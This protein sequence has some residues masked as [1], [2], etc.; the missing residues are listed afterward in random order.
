MK[1]PLLFLLAFLATAFAAKAQ[2]Q[3][4]FQLFAPAGDVMQRPT[5]I[6]HAGDERLFVTSQNG[7]IYILNPSGEYLEQ[8]F[9]D[10]TERVQSSGNEQGL[11]GLAFDPDFENNNRF[12]VNYTHSAEGS[13]I[14]R[15]SRFLVSDDPNVADAASE[16][17]LLEFS[18]PFSN[19]NGGHIEF[20]PDGYL[21]IGTGDG[22]SYGDPMN[23]AQSLTTLLGKML[24]IDVSGETYSIPADNPFVGV[25]DARE[26][27]WAY[28]LRNPWKFH[29]DTASG[30]IFIADV[31]QGEWEEVNVHPLTDGGANFGWRCYEAEEAYD[32]SECSGDEDIA[33]P[34]YQYPHSTGGCSVTGG[35]VY[36]GTEFPNLEDKYFFCDYCSGRFYLMYTA[37]T[38][39]LVVEESTTSTGFGIAAFGTN[40]DG[41]V[42]LAN[43]SSGDIFKLIDN[44]PQYE[45]ELFQYDDS[46]VVFPD[47]GD[48]YIWYENNVAQPPSSNPYITNLQE[49]AIYYVQIFY[50]DSCSLWSEILDTTTGVDE[51][52][53]KP[54]E[55]LLFPNPTAGQL[56]VQLPP[57]LNGNGKVEIKDLTGKTLLQGYVVNSA[58]AELDV[59]GLASGVYVVMVSNDHKLIG[60]RKFVKE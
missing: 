24:R 57:G 13:T 4:D 42:F 58:F 38:G 49:S 48:Q 20:G 32:L 29:I 17:V 45:V 5:T 33:F 7:R 25:A 34:V 53:G 26:E 16:V 15:V 8:P 11:L 41:A 10:I 55:V 1:K 22:G 36:H 59:A 40:I 9:L 19:H 21:Y 44:C 39:D 50:G 6:T 51:A 35:V 31:G 46:L 23:N 3:I 14:T 12:Y 60:T 28:G 27:I 18:Q 47:N 52:N 43:N 54:T 30:N 2:S 56:K 37:P